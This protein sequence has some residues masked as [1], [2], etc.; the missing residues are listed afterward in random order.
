[1]DDVVA[2]VWHERIIADIA[3]RQDIN[4]LAKALAIRY[5]DP[6]RM[7]VSVRDVVRAIGMDQAVV[8]HANAEIIAGLKVGGLGDFSAQHA[9]RV[10]AEQAKAHFPRPQARYPD[11]RLTF[12]VGGDSLVR[13]RWRRLDEVQSPAVAQ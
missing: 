7:P 10:T 12:I 4:V 11:D 9:P 13:S 1:L 2:S 6:A 3:A 8:D 5:C